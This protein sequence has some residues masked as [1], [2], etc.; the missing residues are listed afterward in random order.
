MTQFYPW[1]KI[2]GKLFTTNLIFKKTKKINKI[3]VSV[4]N[5]AELDKILKCLRQM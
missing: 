4:Y 3:G 1:I 2:S 5:K